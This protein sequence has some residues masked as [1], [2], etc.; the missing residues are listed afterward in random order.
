VIDRG[1][2][3]M[4]VSISEQADVAIARLSA[5]E[6]AGHA[7]LA[8]AAVEAVAAA[9]SEIAH[10]IALYAGRGEIAMASLDA[11]GRRGMVVIARDTGPGIADIE[12]A[13]EDG[14]STGGSLG[15]GLPAARRLMD[16]FKLRSRPGGG[17]T[18][19]MV[20]WAR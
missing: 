16:E 13:M 14:Y 6:L 5:R 4:E 19:V 7:G 10:N 17:T 15:L 8:E 1:A 12:R 20:K 2:R 18:V 11:R 9:V 3:R